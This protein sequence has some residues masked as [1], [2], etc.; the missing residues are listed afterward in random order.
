MRAGNLDREI[1]IET[2]SSSGQD[3]YGTPQETWTP[4]GTVR[5]QIVQ[6]STDEYFRAS[7]EG[8][9]VTTV[10]R[11]RYIAG[12][13]NQSRIL[14]EGRTFDIEEVKEL[15]RRRGLELRAKAPE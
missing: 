12:V 14:F 3:E 11:T 7:G 8:A 10:F 4:L 2:Y 13:T 5:A 1:S 9:T 15:G 6:S